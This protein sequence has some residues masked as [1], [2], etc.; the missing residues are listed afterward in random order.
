[1]STGEWTGPWG[2]K[3]EENWTDSCSVCDCG[4]F[5]ACCIAAGM[6]EAVGMD[7]KAQGQRLLGVRLA[8]QKD[9]MF[10]MAMEEFCLLPFPFAP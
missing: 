4:P 2:D 8:G 6:K 9:G 3:D 10:W 5:T 7:F 1:M